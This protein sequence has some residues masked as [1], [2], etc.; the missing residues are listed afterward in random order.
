MPKFGIARATGGGF[1]TPKSHCS[2]GIADHTDDVCPDRVDMLWFQAGLATALNRP[3][4]V[5]RLCVSSYQETGMPI[6]FY[7]C[8]ASL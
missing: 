8:P 4:L 2:P 3:D 1:K 5:K 6:P 7:I